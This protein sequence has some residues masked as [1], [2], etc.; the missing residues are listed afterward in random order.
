MIR[1][2][3]ALAAAFAAVLPATA[4]TPECG[5]GCTPDT[6]VTAVYESVSARPDVGWDWGRVRALFHGEGL[7]AS[8]MTTPDGT[9]YSAATV[10]QLIANTE[11]AYRK[12][13]FV[14]REIRREMRIFGDMAS[15]YSSFYVKIR[16]EDPK[17]LM[18]GLHHFQ[19]LKVDGRW[20]IV[21]NSAV[22]EGGGWTLP[23]EFLPPDSMQKQLIPKQD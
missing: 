19:L 18:R 1:I 22:M 5:D 3:S 4:A 10:E 7:L 21:S 23:A 2:M 6:L 14:E 11:A 20:R 15:V 17:P 9:R 8:V 13:G 12:S 16:D